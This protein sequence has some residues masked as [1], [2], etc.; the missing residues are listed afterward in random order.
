MSNEYPKML[1]K[2]GVVGR[3][4][5]L[6]EDCVIVADKDEEAGKKKDGY[7]DPGAAKPGKADK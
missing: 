5:V 3:D 2:G 4:P 1:Y 7:A 6:G